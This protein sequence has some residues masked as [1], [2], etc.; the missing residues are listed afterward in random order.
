ML[1]Q[2][3]VG[4]DDVVLLV[5][6]EQVVPAVVD[7][8]VNIG[9]MD[10]ITVEVGEEARSGHDLARELDDLDAPISESAD[11]A[12]CDATAEPDDQ[13][14][15]GTWVDGHGQRAND[16]MSLHDVRPAARLR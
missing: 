15:I 5:R 4:G 14:P 16:P 13:R 3:D 11:T 1:W 9:S 6:R 12:G 7:A 2:D 10:H 8:H